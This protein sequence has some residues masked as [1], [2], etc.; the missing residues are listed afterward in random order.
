MSVES[1]SGD[2]ERITLGRPSQSNSAD[3]RTLARDLWSLIMYSTVFRLRLMAS[4]L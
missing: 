4:L 1:D 3:N 2:T